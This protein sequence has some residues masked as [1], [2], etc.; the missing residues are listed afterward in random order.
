MRKIGGI[1][2]I[3]SVWDSTA[4]ILWP[5]RPRGFAC[6]C[7]SL[8]FG[9]PTYL[10]TYERSCCE[11]VSLIKYRNDNAIQQKIPYRRNCSQ[12]FDDKYKYSLV[13]QRERNLKSRKWL[14]FVWHE[15]PKIV[16]E[17]VDFL[18][19]NELSSLLSVTENSKIIAS[20][21]LPSGRRG[22]YR[23]LLRRII[24]DCSRLTILG[25]AELF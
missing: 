4:A 25:S 21:R 23:L 24:T 17:I 16:E 19:T 22:L 12:S 3:L 10:C 2:S 8:L 13:K 5:D 18:R 9:D 7:V 1:I 20:E 6:V 11:I 14:S 15:H